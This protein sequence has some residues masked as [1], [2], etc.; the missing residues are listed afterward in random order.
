MSKDLWLDC[1]DAASDEFPEGTPEHVICAR[2]DELCAER[3]ADAADA[4]YERYRD[5][6]TQTGMYDHDD[7]N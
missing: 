1:Y 2:A 6:A 7:V 3:E 5:A 4:A